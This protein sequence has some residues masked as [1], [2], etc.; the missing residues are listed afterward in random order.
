MYIHDLNI[1]LQAY[2]ERMSSVNPPLN[3]GHTL[4]I[5]MGP[6]DANCPNANSMKKAGRPTKARERT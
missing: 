2:F 3:K 6:S 5:V 4:H 1:Q